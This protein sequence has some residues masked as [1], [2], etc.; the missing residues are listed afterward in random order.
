MEGP[1]PLSISEVP[2]GQPFPHDWFDDDDEGDEDETGQVLVHAP[3]IACLGFTER[4]DE[5]VPF[6]CCICG[7][8]LS[9]SKRIESLTC[10]S[11]HSFVY[12]AKHKRVPV[13]WPIFLSSLNVQ[14][15]IR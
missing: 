7:D 15:S 6:F 14:L 11:E 8:P 4:A 9:G 1:S 12:C 5:P 13:S 10:A 2:G 3:G